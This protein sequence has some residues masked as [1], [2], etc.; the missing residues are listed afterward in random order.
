MAGKSRSSRNATKHG[1][2]AAEI[3]KDLP[4][5]RQILREMRQQKEKIRLQKQLNRKK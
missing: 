4:K 3:L 5:W 2:Y 1:R